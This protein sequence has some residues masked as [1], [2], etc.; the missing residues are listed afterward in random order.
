MS[1]KTKRVGRP[2]KPKA[3][4]FGCRLQ[5]VM[6]EKQYTKLKVEARKQGETVADFVR[7]RILFEPKE[8]VNASGQ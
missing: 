3:E 6:T 4:I 5:V 8:S 7:E 2:P 1:K